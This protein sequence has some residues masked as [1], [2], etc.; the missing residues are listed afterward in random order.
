MIRSIMSLRAEQ[1][2]RKRFQIVNDNIF[3]LSLTFFDASLS[4]CRF[5]FDEHRI[6]QLESLFFTLLFDFVEQ[7]LTA[8]FAQ[9]GNVLSDR[10]K[11]WRHNLV[12]KDA[13][14]SNDPVIIG[15]ACALFLDCSLDSDGNPVACT[16]KC[17]IFGIFFPIF[18]FSPAVL[19]AIITF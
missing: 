13:I 16:D 3:R 18:F 6:K 2:L 14:I 9:F 5:S 1:I 12:Q 8:D 11:P 7:H 17:R 15:N 4:A 19:L 10:C